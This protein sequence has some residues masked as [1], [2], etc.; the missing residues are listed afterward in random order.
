MTLQNYFLAI[1]FCIS[2]GALVLAILAYTKKKN[3]GEL[4]I[5][6]KC[7]VGQH[8][9]PEHELADPITGCMLDTDM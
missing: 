5:K 3:G 8:Y 9:H 6:K 4:Y 2:I 1:L 7:P